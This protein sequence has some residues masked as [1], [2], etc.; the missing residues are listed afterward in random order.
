MIRKKEVC[1]C[2]AGSDS[3]GGAG[4]QADIKS[5]SSEGSYVA[6]AITAI[7]AQNTLGVQGSFELDLDFF[8]QQLQSI[9]SDL[10]PNYVKVGMLYSQKI[11]EMVEIFLTKYKPKYVVFDPVMVATSGDK[12]IQNSTI[13]R[14]RDSFI[15]YCNIVTPNLYEAEILTDFRITNQHDMQR[16][17]KKIL[18]YGCDWVLIK[19]GHLRMSDKSVDILMSKQNTYILKAKFLESGNVHGTG[20]SLSSAITA[21]LARKLTVPEAVRRAKAFV[22][23]GIKYGYEISEGANP[24]NQHYL[25][26]NSS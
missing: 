17:A 15:S 2:I 24:I 8:E 7:T 10:Q 16:A 6:T 20:C 19:G 11:A 18:Q 5:F 23:M 9:F 3:G 21:N 22:Y 26:S 13:S 14:I 25:H 1:L 4:I 12:L